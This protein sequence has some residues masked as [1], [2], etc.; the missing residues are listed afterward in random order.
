MYRIVIEINEHFPKLDGVQIITIFDHGNALNDKGLPVVTA[1]SVT[2]LKLGT[3]LLENS[4]QVDF[5]SNSRE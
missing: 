2:Q 4:L 3:K 5:T 1:G